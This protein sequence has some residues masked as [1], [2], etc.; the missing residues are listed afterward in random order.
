LLSNDLAGFA[1]AIVHGET[2]A[3]RLDQA[4]ADYPVSVA[5]EV[6]RH[7]Y[8]G[9]LQDALAGAYPVVKQLVG[10]DF[11]RFMAWKFISQ[12]P[13]R[14]AN[15]HRYGAE[16]VDFVAAFEPAG[17]LVYLADMARLE[18]ACH[19]AYFAEE[20]ET[21]DVSALATIPSERY[22]DLVLRIH[23][24]C[25]VMH[26]NF[27]VAAIWQAHQPGAPADFHIDLGS[28]PVD[29]LICRSGD[30]VQV[31]ELVAAEAA[32]LQLIKAGMPMGAATGV[33]MEHHADFDL[34]EA[35]QAFV[36]RGAIADFEL[37]RPT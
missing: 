30:V 33:I 28:G 8:R 32:W 19:V 37:G 9:N 25:C 2:P 10:D 1:R 13:S 3:L 15:L 21:L 36:A 11:F 27:P 26:S 35:L 12:W 18:W 5:V 4:Y 16:L 17:E 20:D 14:N 22:A 29:A 23:P 6:Y 31:G 34:P 7:N 24:T